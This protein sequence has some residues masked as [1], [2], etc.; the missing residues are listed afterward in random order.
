[1]ILDKLA[2]IWNPFKR[3]WKP[4]DRKGKPI[5]D[6]WQ[7]KTEKEIT[8]RVLEERFLAGENPNKRFAVSAG[9]ALDMTGNTS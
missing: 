9:S 4:R 7:R 1:M 3:K 5:F 2:Y 6:Y 8:D